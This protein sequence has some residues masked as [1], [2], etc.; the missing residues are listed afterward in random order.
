MRPFCLEFVKTLT[1]L[2]HTGCEP[3]Q[4]YLQHYQLDMSA[5][6]PGVWQRMGV[7][8]ASGYRIVAQ[9]FVPPRPRATLVILHGYY[10][11]L[12]L[13]GHLISWALTQHFAVIGCDLPGHGLSSGSR[14]S[15][16]AFSE[17][18]QVLAGLLQEAAK[19]ALPTPWHLCGQSTGAAIVLEHLLSQPHSM[20]GTS[21]LLAPLVRPRAWG[22]SRLAYQ[23][24]KP[25][26]RQ[27]P[28]RFS[29]NSTDSAFVHFIRHQ[30][31][32]Q[33][34]VLP[35][36]WVGALAGWI[37]QIEAARPA[38]KP[39]LIIQGEADQTV[40]WQYN[41]KVLEQKLPAAR[42]LLLP[43]ARHHLVNEVAS[44]R[45]HYLSF[46]EQALTEG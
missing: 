41:L 39:A 4:G 32:L 23:L 38:S 29:D 19:L 21:I 25:W 12:G 5:V 30:D 14:A 42:T 16:G 34:Q 46:I 24:L 40:A 17:Y 18:Q 7:F 37:K 1:P 15:I 20:L 28:R 27:M 13:Y 3:A 26:V 43:Q 8:E 35:T 10:D 45:D 22:R 44:I 31:P 2:S 11:H 36:A 6:C 9:S 33:P